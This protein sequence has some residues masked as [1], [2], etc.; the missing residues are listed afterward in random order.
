MSLKQERESGHSIDLSVKKLE[1]R[2]SFVTMI[3]S[4]GCSHKSID[5]TKNMI[6]GVSLAD[7]A[8][9]VVSA[10]GDDF[11]KG[12][13]ENKI[14]RDHALIAHRMGV[15]KIIVVIN[16]MDETDPEYSEKR[17]VEIKN[18]VAEQLTRIGFEQS[19]LIIIPV[20]GLNGD[21]LIEDS[22]KLSWLTEKLLTSLSLPE[23]PSSITTLIDA[24]DAIKIPEKEIKIPLRVLIYLVFET[25]KKS[26]CQKTG[27]KLCGRIVSGIL[28]RGQE[29]N[30]S[31]INTNSIIKSI[32]KNKEE[33]DIATAGDVVQLHIPD[34][35]PINILPGYVLSDRNDRPAKQCQSFTS[36]IT[37]FDH[38]KEI[39]SGY[40]VFIHCHAAYFPC[41]IQKICEKIDPNTGE[42]VD[43]NPES[44]KNDE[45]LIVE[46]V[47]KKAIC[48]EMYDDFPA[49][50][51]FVIRKSGKLIGFGKVTEVH[52]INKSDSPEQEELSS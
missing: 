41:T 11:E 36:Q 33:V 45:T 2:R 12:M 50:A 3:D 16:K 24:I 43:L 4:P 44:I 22:K 38:P 7:C 9:L 42:T 20:S 52:H 27:S 37:I 15:E 47:P 48:V 10:L 1:T 14:T 5:H 23:R 40:S 19:N 35:L 17:Y 18:Q 30:I 25:K 49:L 6:V 34:V 8:I 51:R 39:H 21:N 46:M 26:M 13:H 31:P 29:I 28:K 32:K